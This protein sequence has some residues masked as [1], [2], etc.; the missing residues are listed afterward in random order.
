M[1]RGE[2]KHKELDNY[3]HTCIGFLQRFHKSLR[4]WNWHHLFLP[5]L[6][7]CLKRWSGKSSIYTTPQKQSNNDSQLLANQRCTSD[8]LCMVLYS[9]IASGFTEIP[10]MEVWKHHNKHLTIVGGSYWSFTRC[11]RLRISSTLQWRLWGMGNWLV[12][13][14]G[15]LRTKWKIQQIPG[16]GGAAGFGRGAFAAVVVWEVTLELRLTWVLKQ[17]P[18]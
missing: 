14:K 7:Q 3:L 18:K 6:L 5:G 10:D 11:R 12:R 8:R 4:E 16:G 17:T 2:R 1:N 15:H 13:L 9:A